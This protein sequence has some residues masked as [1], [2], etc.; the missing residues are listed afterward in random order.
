MSNIS[1]FR[2]VLR[3]SSFVLWKW[4]VVLLLVAISGGGTA[5]CACGGLFS[6]ESLLLQ[7]AERIIF[8]DNGD[9][10]ISTIVQIQ[11]S[12]QEADF[13]WI[14]PIP[15]GIPAEAIELPET[16][17]N[18]FRELEFSTRPVY[19]APDPP[20]CAREFDLGSIFFLGVGSGAPDGVNV[21]SSGVVGPYGFDVI[22]SENPTALIDWLRER[23]Y[24]VTAEMEPLIAAYVQEGMYF[25]AMQL[26]PGSGVQDIQPVKVTFHATQP[27]IPLR[28]A[29]VAAQPDTEILVWFFANAP[30]TPTNYTAMHIA[31]DELTFYDDNTHNYDTLLRQR[32]DEYQGQA[33]ITEYAGPTSGK[34]FND[35]LLQELIQQHA[36][37][38]RLRATISPEE[39]TVDP[40]FT[41]DPQLPDVSNVHN[42]A[43]LDGLY[44]CE[45]DGSNTRLIMGL[46]VGV[47]VLVS[48]GTWLIRRRFLR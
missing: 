1:W 39:M 43:E 27:M 6:P 21:F 34:P 44:A 20:L 22:S 2:F 11:Y 7:N 5:V 8:S 45:R 14:L 12:G 36:Y 23:N 15:E 38:T 24:Q 17:E 16:A 10:T 31:D 28:M 4:V 25:L 26:A 41:F 40:V 32:A 33:F 3:P 37:L 42:L 35:P 30:A 9:G 29:A 13:S 46:G 47:V 48:G 19:L 18:A